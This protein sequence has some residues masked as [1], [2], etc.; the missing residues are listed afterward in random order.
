ME[1]IWEGLQIALQPVNLIYIVIGLVVGVFFGSLPG[2]TA[3]MGVAVMVPFSYYL[4]PNA[5][6]LL[7]SGVFCGA[8]YGGSV[9]AVLLGIPGTPASVPTAWEGYPMAR[10]GEAGKAMHLVTAASTFG[11]IASSIALMFGAPLLAAFALKFGAPETMMLAVFGMTVVCSLTSGNMVKGILM[12]FFSMLLGCV[13]QDPVNGFPRFTFGSIQLI[14]GLQLVPVLIGVFSLPEVFVLVEDIIKERVHK[15]EVEKIK[16]GKLR[17][18]PK[19]FF[20]HVITM[21]K[22][23]VIGIIIGIIPAA[24]ADIAAFLSYN[25]AKR[26]SKHPE[27]FTKGEPDG[28]VAAESANNAVTGASLIPLLTLSIPG[29][30]PAALY[31]GVLYI[32]GLRPGPTLFSNN[33]GIVYSLLAGFLIVNVLMYFVGLGYCKIAG[34]VVRVKREIL[35]PVIITLTVI[36]AYAC[37]RSWFDVGVM[38]AVGVIGY[39]LVKCGFPLSPIAL[40]LILGPI[41]EKAF[42]QTNVIFKGD[43]TKLFTRPISMVLLAIT[44][45]TLVWPF[46]R[47]AWNRRKAKKQAAKAEA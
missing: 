6:L 1:L 34:N 23:S 4:S 3:T 38:F 33:P 43:F 39:L 25:E 10:R 45:F 36:G 18:K 19:E 24:S 11:G 44:V 2:I 9:S 7:M 13:G 14:S 21:V 42:T 40:G 41:F 27:N 32:N 30:A 12:G 26:A 5:A 29:S 16:V 17:M 8:I 46:V 28:L 35:V 31:L 47:T 22:S 20:S 15:V 37:N